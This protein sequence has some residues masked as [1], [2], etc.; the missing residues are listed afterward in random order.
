MLSSLRPAP[1]A[2]AGSSAPRGRRA[3][4]VVRASSGGQDADEQP[5]PEVPK[6]RRRSRRK[7]KPAEQPFTID[8]LNPVTMGRKSREV[9]D[10]VWTQLQRI[11]NPTR[12]SQVADTFTTLVDVPEYESP[13]APST[14]VLVTGATGRVGRVLVRK[15]LLRGYKVRAL[16]RTRRDGSAAAGPAASSGEADSDSGASGSG[17][18]EAFPQSVEIVYGDLGD[19]QACRAA[20]EGVDKI[21]CCSGARSTITADLNRVEEQGVA[22]LA[23]AFLDAQNARARREGRLAPTSKREL[24]DFKREEH[25]EAW[26]IVAVGPPQAEEEP[27]S[28]GRR[29]AVERARARDSA[30]C[31]INE[32]DN[33]VFEGAVYSRGG[34]AEVGAPLQL[35]EG[36]SLEGAD[37]LVLRV[38]ADEHA[39][40]CVLRVAGGAL[41]TNRF[42][43]RV[44]YNTLRL[45]FNTFRPVNADDPPLRPEEVEY[46][47]LRFEPRIKVLEQ[48][49]EPGQSMFDTSANRFRLEV[50]WIKALPGGVETDFILVSCAG[51]PRPDLD[52]AQREKVVG[53]KRRGEAILRNSGL[54]YTI[55]RP[56]PL[57][58]EAGG[59]K[60]LVF[61]QARAAGNRITQGISC[62][63]VADICLK[64]INNPE[65]RNKTFEVCFEYEPEEGLEFYELISHLPDKS[66]SYLTPALAPLTKNT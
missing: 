47:G 5:L 58:E 60:A 31:Y 19:Y 7:E 30:E 16:V 32:D 37:G 14:T 57:V 17:E 35:P 62:A 6:Q 25:H 26:D 36:E 53:A 33:L 45:P 18:A 22:N 34:I 12:S 27:R 49:T 28:K 13:D 46:I 64:A 52:D 43:T 15:L 10:D 29:R 63:D 20:V 54:G 40:T 61:D 24:A 1:A 39:Y 3:A 50:D 8:T 51:T 38:R 56:G 59:Y 11:G 23:R 44:G 2:L 66:N 65:A 42:G 41:Y 9:F 48:V 21:V 55:V 4:L